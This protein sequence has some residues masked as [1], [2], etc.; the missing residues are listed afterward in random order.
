MSQM[1]VQ[2]AFS[3]SWG[4]ALNDDGARFR[5]WAPGQQAVKLRLDGREQPMQA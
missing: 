2:R 3:T 4:T 5:L 1:Q